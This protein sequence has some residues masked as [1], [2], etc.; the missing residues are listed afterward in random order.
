MIL[1]TKQW[2][3]LAAGCIC[4]KMWPLT[5]FYH[6]KDNGQWLL[7]WLFFMQARLHGPIDLQLSGVWL[8]S[9][10]FYSKPWWW[11]PS[12]VRRCSLHQV[13][14]PIKKMVSKLNWKKEI[15]HLQEQNN[16][17]TA[18]I[19]VLRC[20]QGHTVWDRSHPLVEFRCSSSQCAISKN[21]ATYLRWSA[22][23]I[24]QSNTTTISCHYTQIRRKKR[25]KR[26]DY[27][28][29]PPFYFPYRM[30]LPKQLRQDLM[31]SLRQ[32]NWTP[33]TGVSHNNSPRRNCLI[34][35]KVIYIIFW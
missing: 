8:K 29:K 13:V 23:G 18:T 33:L 5:N 6:H 17:N 32:R 30:D 24:L 28:D 26:K 2:I 14:L 12:G 22:M 15:Q 9:I 25:A 19:A 3:H 21:A 7:F 31:E 11:G 27:C 16:Q 34:P 10:M 4:C 1:I 35:L 20:G